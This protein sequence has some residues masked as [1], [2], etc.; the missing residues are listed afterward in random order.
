MEQWITEERL[1]WIADFGLKVAGV[2]ALMLAALY[3]SSMLKRFLGRTL[4]RSGLDLTVSRFTANLSRWAVLTITAIS[5]LGIF[6]VETTS[7][8]AVLASLSFAVGLAFQGSLSNFSSGIMLLIFRPFKTGDFIRAAGSDGTVHQIDLF[9]T[10][11]D[12]PDNRRIILPNSAVFGSTIENVSYHPTRRVDVTVGTEYCADI[13]RTRA[14]L[15]A[16]AA[17]VPDVLKDP[18]PQVVLTGLG[19]SSIDWAV[20]T[21]C[22]AAAYWDVRDACIRAV[23]LSLDEAGIGI[24][25]PNMEM[26]VLDLPEVEAAAKPGPELHPH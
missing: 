11:L 22:P 17:N 3:L 24:P 4:E 26:H 6:G 7:F 9:T 14:V 20:R 15:A 23:K 16:A 10:T 12:T 2:V 13:D 21:W 1:N 5:C 8:A 18:A 19:D 25:F